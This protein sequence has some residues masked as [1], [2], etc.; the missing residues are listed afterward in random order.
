M[1]ENQDSNKIVWKPNPGPQ[2]QFVACEAD[3]AVYGGGAG[4]E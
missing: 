3:I 2:E 1:E 4:G